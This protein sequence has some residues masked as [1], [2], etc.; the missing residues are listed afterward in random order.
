MIDKD[1][2]S[3]EYRYY[4]SN[5]F[6]A[7]TAGQILWIWPAFSH[8]QITIQMRG[9][10]IEFYPEQIELRIVYF[11]QNVNFTGLHREFVS[12]FEKKLT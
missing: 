1:K 10:L 11:Y 7:E 8:V 4:P 6:D 9:R 5:D 3:S 2:P 12:F